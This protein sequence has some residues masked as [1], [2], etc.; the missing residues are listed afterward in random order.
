[1]YMHSK[2]S[3]CTLEMYTVLFANYTSIKLLGEK[4]ISTARETEA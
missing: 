4:R 1:M 3:R 2:S